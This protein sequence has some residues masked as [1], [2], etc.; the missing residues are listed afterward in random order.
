MTRLV[1]YSREL[2]IGAD[3]PDDVDELKLAGAG[4]V[5]VD[6]ASVD[7]RKRPALAECLGSLQEGDVLVVSSSDRLSHGLSHFV[8]TVT[9]L[10]AR[11][12]VFR[13]LTESALCTDAGP[14]ADASQ[15]LAALEG[16]RRRLRSLQTREGMKA[17]A[18][19]GRRAGRP[20]VM[21]EERIGIAHELRNHGRSFTHI[22]EVL[23][24]STSTVQR[25][26]TPPADLTAPP[27]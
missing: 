5:F 4:E 10:G 20:T 7:P 8:A 9:A 11:G 19:A 17:A 26:L 22:A 18:A 3:T 24:V 12:V 6:A 23:G 27:T 14:P 21:T 16:L 2:L 13:S 15:V 1:G 25:A